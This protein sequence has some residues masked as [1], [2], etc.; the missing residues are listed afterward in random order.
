MNEDDGC[1]GVI[2]N[3]KRE[4]LRLKVPVETFPMLAWGKT[5]VMMNILI[6]MRTV[7][8]KVIE[9]AWESRRKDLAEWATPADFLHPIIPFRDPN[10]RRFVRSCYDCRATGCRSANSEEIN[11]F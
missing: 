9:F 6:L 3:G 7:C 5:T 11:R 8:P 1:L 4:H 10:Q 2:A